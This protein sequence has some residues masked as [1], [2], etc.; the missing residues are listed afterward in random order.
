M[1]V[2]VVDLRVVEVVDEL[3]VEV[4]LELGLAGFAASSDVV[5]TVDDEVDVV[6]PSWAHADKEKIK[7]VPM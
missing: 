5:V 7:R 6:F 4:E 3:E 2:V 1:V